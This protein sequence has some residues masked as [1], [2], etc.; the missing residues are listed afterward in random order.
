[1]PRRF[2]A[3]LLWLAPACAPVVAP[4]GPAVRDAEIAEGV[5]VAED[6]A[7]LALQVWPA[8]GSPRAVI[9]AL[10]GFNDYRMAF[11]AAAETW[12][13]EGVATYAYDQRGF[14]ES[15]IAGL[16]AGTETL[17]G[18]A[19][20][21]VDLV[22]ARLPGVPVF[23]L[24]HSMGGAAAAVAALDDPP[25]GLAG[26]I[27]VAPAVWGFDTLPWS[28]RALLWLVAHAAPGAR[29]SAEGL[30]LAPSDNIAM[31]RA[32]ARD[33]LVLDDARADAT[34]GLVRLM[35]DGLAAA[36][37]TRLPILVVYGARDEIVP[38]EPVAR[39]AAAL[40]GPIR[41]AVYP[42]GC[43]MALR[44]LR[45]DV[46]IRDVARFVLDPAAPLPSGLEIAPGG[47]LAAVDALRRGAVDG[48][49]CGAATGV[50]ERPRAPFSRPPPLRP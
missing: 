26:A 2:L 44:D 50:A 41:A 37:A 13:R 12:R 6:G 8:E 48:G 10:H 35:D 22:A 43:H 9:V 28:H 24:G 45:R 5:I 39:F 27:L 30:D 34:L 20:A 47:L 46:P 23:L 11:A 49:R 4:S 38:P 14:G 17:A 7:R 40:D 16:W 31:L 33:P 32:L 18:D 19:R 3:M 29:L 21:V 25:P 36:G 1:M 15:D 42:D